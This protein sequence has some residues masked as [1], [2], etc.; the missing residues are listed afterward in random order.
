[1]LL[2]SELTTALGSM[3][4]KKSPGPDGLSVEFYSKFWNL[5]GPILLE[6]INLCYA[7]FDLR[8]LMKTIT[9]CLFLRKATERA[10]R[11]GGQSCS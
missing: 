4:R 8:D 10:S 2:L 9:R 1:M 5:L 6:V 11:I 3:S 7:D